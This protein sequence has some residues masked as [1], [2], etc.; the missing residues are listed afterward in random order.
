VAAS[1]YGRDNG[2]INVGFTYVDPLTLAPGEQAAYD[3]IFAY[4]PRYA[5]QQVI[6]FEE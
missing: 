5:S 3:V 4:Y 6:A 1:I 2:L